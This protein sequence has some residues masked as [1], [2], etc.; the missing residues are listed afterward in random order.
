MDLTEQQR[1]LLRLLPAVDRVL[2]LA[3]TESGFERVP[4]SVVVGS[5]RS[6][7]DAQL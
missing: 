3:Q 5:I 4:T 2:A 7:I 1:H 6:V